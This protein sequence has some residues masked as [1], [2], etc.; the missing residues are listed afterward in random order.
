MSG[1]QSQHKARDR[2]LR[3][4]VRLGHILPLSA[5]NE[6][7][8]LLTLCNAT[9][10]ENTNTLF[11]QV[12]CKGRSNPHLAAAQAVPTVGRRVYFGFALCL[13]PPLH[14]YFCEE[15][16]T[17]SEGALAPHLLRAGQLIKSGLVR[18]EQAEVHAAL[19]RVRWGEGMLPASI[20]QG[21]RDSGCSRNTFSWHWILFARS[22][23]SRFLLFGHR[24][25]LR[26]QLGPV[27]AM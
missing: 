9:A 7:W 22:L 19:Q 14:L 4:A 27:C 8:C 23:S 24:Q 26:R 3:L 18:C 2:S 10:C 5:V 21:G 20:F 25:Y 17:S 13:L 12:R 6:W 11:L 15:I 16:Q 1:H